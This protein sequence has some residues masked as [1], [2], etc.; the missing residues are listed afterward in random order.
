[1]DILKEEDDDRVIEFSQNGFND[2]R[3]SILPVL[4]DNLIKSLLEQAKSEGI[5]VTEDFKSGN[6]YK[7]LQ[8]LN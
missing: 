3:L 6:F 8:F 7:K 1:M 2:D 4:S 5:F